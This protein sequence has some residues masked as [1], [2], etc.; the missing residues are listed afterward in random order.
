MTDNNENNQTPKVKMSDLTT[1]PQEPK[2]NHTATIEQSTVNTAQPKG[3]KRATAALV[4][5]LLV[6]GIFSA[7]GFYQYQQ[8]QQL[9]F[10]LQS[11][12]NRLKAE[13]R[14]QQSTQQ[15][16][17]DSQTKQL[18]DQTAVQLEQQDKTIKSLQLAL[19]DIKGRHPNDWLLAEADYLVKM[20][21]RKLF[22]EHDPES[23]TLLMESADQRIASLNDPSLVSL[24][25][26]IAQD[27]TQLKA[28]PLIDK[29]GLVIKL[30][31]LQQQ[32]DQLPLANALLPEAKPEQKQ[33]V[34]NDIYDWKDNLLT[35][36]KDFASHF[37]TFRTREGNVVPLLSPQ[38]HFYLKENVKAKLDT[39]IKGVYSENNDIYQKGLAIALEW[40]Q[41]FFNQDTLVVKKFQQQLEQLNQQNVQVDYPVQLVSQKS[42]AEVI[43]D[44][45]RR[46]VTAVG[47]EK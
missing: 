18:K 44:R 29:E 1:K 41:Q 27:I 42:L 10:Q 17:L 20:A 15:A 13:I 7:F 43:T 31:T 47:E 40:S 32:V 24:R 6:A 30:L 9:L 34:S 35:S 33:T 37:I 45:L 21:G 5:T 36:L 22:L 23:A 38:Q 3:S 16:K 46:S 4:I 25:K 8:N 2:T 12:V 19:A 14:Q 11:H 39:T 26:E 28:L